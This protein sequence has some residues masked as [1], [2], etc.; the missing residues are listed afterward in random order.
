MQIAFREHLFVGGD[1]NHFGVKVGADGGV[2][3]E[4]SLCRAGD[5]QDAV[6]GLVVFGHA[7]MELGRDG[8]CCHR[9]SGRIN[10]HHTAA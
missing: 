3:V 7:Q 6:L 10:T 4:I 8:V 9:P 5:N 2:L 1:E